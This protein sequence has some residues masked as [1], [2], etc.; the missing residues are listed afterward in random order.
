[1]INKLKNKSKADIQRAL[2]QVYKDVKYKFVR[3][4]NTKRLALIVGCQRS[5]STMLYEIFCKD[6]RSKVFGEF[7]YLNSQDTTFNIRLN[8]IEEVE[9]ILTK[10]NHPLIVMKPLVESQNIHSLLELSPNCKVIW[11]YRHYNDV[12]A[13]N[14]K[15]WGLGNGIN[16]LRPIVTNDQSNWRSEKVSQHVRGKVLQLFK[17][18]MPTLD[19]AALFWWVRNRLFFEQQL[20]TNA[21]VY[22]CNYQHLVSAPKEEMKKIYNFIDFPYPGDHIVNHVHQKSIGKGKEVT[23]SPE[24]KMLC[25]EL[26]NELHQFTNK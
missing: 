4:G 20:E 8:P 6:S 25:E 26:L 23:L 24:I 14:L 2:F 22:L 3:R 19:A 18:D 17:E 10:I 12:A 16:N 7:N 21:D 1:M 13:S 9:P 5:G 11:L 15:K